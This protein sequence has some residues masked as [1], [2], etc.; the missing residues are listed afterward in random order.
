MPRSS[1]NAPKESFPELKPGRKITIVIETKPGTADSS[2]PGS[3]TLTY[4]VV[5][6]NN[7]AVILRGDERPRLIRVR[8]DGISTFI[9]AKDGQRFPVTKITV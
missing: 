2:V 4:R 5:I 9:F 8:E 6:V 1:F 7:R 3:V